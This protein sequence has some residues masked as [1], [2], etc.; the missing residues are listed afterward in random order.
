MACNFPK[1]FNGAPRP[2]GGCWGCRLDRKAQ[3]V[4]RLKHEL[5]YYKKS[6]FITLTY[7]DDSVFSLCKE[8]FVLF[9][10]RMNEHLLRKYKVKGVK[11]FLVG[12]Y[13]DKLGRPHGH[14]IVFGFDFREVDKFKLNGKPKNEDN[15]LSRVWSH[16]F[17]HVGDVTP[18][19][20]GYVAG[21]C[22][23]K[24]NGKKGK[25]I[26]EDNGLEPEFILASKGIGYRYYMDF[27]RKAAKRGSELKIPV[28][29]G[30]SRSWPQFYKR[31]LSGKKSYG[32][33]KRGE[34]FSS[35]KS[36]KE[37]LRVEDVF[38][39]RE[40]Y[41]KYSAQRFQESVADAESKASER[42]LGSRRS[43][44]EQLELESAQRELDSDLRFK[45]KEV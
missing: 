7:E 4:L 44:R 41:R 16:G 43:G 13:G 38:E 35:F 18:Q 33:I 37:S 45:L 32:F 24:I 15:F 10:K 27:L 39:G 30:L 11:Y 12:E 6:C 2:C 26:Y 34:S 21:Y 14:A 17:V 22:M 36:R 40:E 8:D 9:K 1:V 31:K 5:C 19:S 20:I 23:K 3:W 29:K 42:A 28:G 25:A